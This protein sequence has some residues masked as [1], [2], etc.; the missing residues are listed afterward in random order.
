MHYNDGGT[1]L[2][3]FRSSFDA[4]GGWAL[5]FLPLEVHGPL[6]LH[7]SC[8]RCTSAFW[9]EETASDLMFYEAGLYVFGDGE[10][11]TIV[12][13]VLPY[14]QCT[15][16]LIVTLLH[17]VALRKAVEGD[18][19]EEPMSFAGQWLRA[20]GSEGKATLTPFGGDALSGK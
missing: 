12:E 20:E 9:T 15:N 11:E 7:P 4:A 5:D 3:S 16:D 6:E 10:V 8:W 1:L 2:L 13:R 14:F 17:C 19:L 18:V